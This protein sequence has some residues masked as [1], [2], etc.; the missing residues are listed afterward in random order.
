MVHAVDM[1][2]TE[3]PTF[4]QVFVTALVLDLFYSELV[5]VVYASMDV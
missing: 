4:V 5:S 1:G 3:R 2:T